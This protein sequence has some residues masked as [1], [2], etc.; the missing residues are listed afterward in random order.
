MVI[1]Y[2][3]GEYFITEAV[4]VLVCPCYGDSGV[5]SRDY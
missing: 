5:K 2:L 1:K 3:V 4:Q